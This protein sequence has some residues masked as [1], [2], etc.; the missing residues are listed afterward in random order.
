MVTHKKWQIPVNWTVWALWFTV[1]FHFWSGSSLLRCLFPTV[2]LVF[3]SPGV[4]FSQCQVLCPWLWAALSNTENMLVQSSR[5]SSVSILSFLTSQLMCV[6][7]HYWELGIPD[8][9]GTVLAVPCEEGL[10]RELRPRVIIA[11]LPLIPICE[12]GDGSYGLGPNYPGAVWLSWLVTWLWQYQSAYVGRWNSGR[13]RL[14]W[15]LRTPRKHSF[16]HLYMWYCT[17]VCMCVHMCHDMSVKAEGS[18]SRPGSLWPPCVLQALRWGHHAF[19][20]A[21]SAAEPSCQFPSHFIILSWLCTIMGFS[22]TFS[23]FHVFS[24]VDCHYLPN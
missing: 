5:R 20:Q 19:Q 2:W 1:A 13:G 15:G 17:C 3:I 7:V 14:L 9:Q 4:T 6:Q 21:P 22:M 24:Q 23:S 11:P 18:P 10:W 8:C 12:T 16:L